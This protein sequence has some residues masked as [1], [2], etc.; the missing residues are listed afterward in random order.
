MPR[1]FP[2]RSPLAR[3]R[4]RAL[5]VWV[6]G[7][8]AL[9]AAVAA[10]A[11]IPPFDPSFAGGAAAVLESATSD[12]AYAGTVLP[13]GT[14]LAAGDADS[15]AT[16]FAVTPAGQPDPAVGAGSG[17]AQPVLGAPATITG[18]ARDGVGRILIA[19]VLV[20]PADQIRAFAARLTV[21]L[22]LDTT[23][24]TN[25]LTLVVGDTTSIGSSIDL[26]GQG[27]VLVGVRRLG[28]TTASTGAVVRLTPGGAPDATFGGGD[29][30][31]D[32]PG[33][34]FCVAALADGGAAAFSRGDVGGSVVTRLLESGT[35][36]AA[37]GGDGT[38]EIA[39]L[40]AL[41]GGAVDAQGRLLA[42]G[43][44]L[45]TV[46]SQRP[47]VARL[48]PSGAL[49]PTFG[50]G[51]LVT[52]QR[53]GSGASVAVGPDGLIA[54]GGSV[55]G[56]GLSEPYVMLLR[57][58][59]SLDARF[60][61]GGQLAAQVATAG[62]PS[63]SVVQWTTDGKIVAVG[64]S[65]VGP[66]DSPPGQVIVARLRLDRAAPTL[67]VPARVDADATGP[68]GAAVA[69]TVTASDDHDLA[70]VVAC[71]PPS[72]AAF[73][74]GDTT[75]SCSATDA[76]GNTRA[77]SFTVHVRGAQEQFDR[78]RADTTDASLARTLD[79]VAQPVSGSRP[80]CNALS[81]YASRATKLGRAD[82]ASRARRIA[83]V[84]VCR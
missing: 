60:A 81:S 71:T 42:V 76:S 30:I 24:G 8:A 54:V 13:D 47:A 6:A 33:Q 23:F 73:A 70:P 46:A 45:P 36:D 65:A 41:R 84:L 20:T 75:V 43:A 77:A 53:D 5:A 79:G 49:D 48:T 52:S 51:G 83:A 39:A 37:F 17:R 26:D 44:V 2:R 11:S 1:R 40:T 15:V 16:V 74:A 35:P 57:P 25:G 3:Q 78:L 66:A 59:G 31:A 58:D 56:T 34:V 67:T 19:G 29:G 50:S 9:A 14:I 18:V 69:Y 28:T 21:G 80:T 63:F 64:S 55:R 32:A 82:L 27:R 72:G 12:T 10:S 68:A 22:A 4:R 38:V 7:L 61:D 62:S